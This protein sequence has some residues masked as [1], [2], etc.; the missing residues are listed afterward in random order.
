MAS[1]AQKCVP[2]SVLALELPLSSLKKGMQHQYRNAEIP[3]NPQRQCPQLLQMRCVA[4]MLLQ[5]RPQGTG[6]QD[7]LR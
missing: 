2:R 3:F 6:D 1:L 7:R 4:C 5:F